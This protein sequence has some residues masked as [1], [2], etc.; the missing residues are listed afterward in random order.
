MKT[1]RN[2][3]INGSDEAEHTRAIFGIL[4]I[5]ENEEFD[6]EAKNILSPITLIK[7]EAFD[8]SKYPA[9]MDIAIVECLPSQIKRQDAQTMTMRWGGNIAHITTAG[10]YDPKNRQWRT[11]FWNAMHN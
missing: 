9:K 11:K 5:N 8:K 10:E 7:E 1:T 4:P 2:Y 3:I 6:F